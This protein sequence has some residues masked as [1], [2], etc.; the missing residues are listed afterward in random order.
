M[1]RHNKVN[2][3]LIPEIAANLLLVKDALGTST[4]PY[5]LMV[6]LIQFTTKERPKAL[7][8]IG[9]GKTNNLWQE[10]SS[11]GIGIKPLVLSDALLAV[12]NVTPPTLTKDTLLDLLETHNLTTT[13]AFINGWV[14][15]Q[16]TRELRKHAGRV[17]N[18]QLAE[19]RNEQK[20]VHAR[21]LSVREQLSRLQK[22][23]EDLEKRATILTGKINQLRSFPP[24]KSTS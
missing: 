2:E 18:T 22:E 16:E 11:Q 9:Y 5:L 6:D 1:A 20:R 17:L 24:N 3:Q 14:A 23:E 12:A 15:E 21:L 7:D 8:V 13:K 10:Q 19:L 4:L